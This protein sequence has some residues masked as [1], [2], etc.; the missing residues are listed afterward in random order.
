MPNRYRSIFV[1]D[2]HL[3]ATG[4]RAEQVAEFLQN[5]E[6]EY[7]YLVGDVIDQWVLRHG[8]RWTHR[9]TEVIRQILGKEQAGVKVFYTPGNH[10]EALKQMNGTSL[11][12]LRVDREFIHETA[13]GKH[14][15]VTHGDEFD[16]LSTQYKRLAWVMANIYDEITRFNQRC[17]E[18]LARISRRQVDFSTGLKK[19]LKK[20]VKRK[21]S[22][23]NAL[24]E[25]TIERGLDGVVC[26][27]IHT[28]SLYY[29]EGVAY[30]NCGDWVEHATAIV[31]HWDG[32]LELLDWHDQ[33]IRLGIPGAAV[34]EP[35]PKP[36][37]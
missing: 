27:H 24:L 1:S 18:L 3:G 21:T 14:I 11:G 13:D 32:R 4:S 16:R 33:M 22:F 25:S 37:S 9:H 8:E 34:V 6:S 35:L 36:Q 30:A 5:T 15:L 23:E 26:G 28:P 29:L 7:L 12:H 17:N 19:K 20:V 10:D 31:E 2:L